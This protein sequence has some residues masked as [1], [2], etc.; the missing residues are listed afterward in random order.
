MKT[1]LLLAFATIL[2]LSGCTKDVYTIN[3]TVEIDFNDSESVSL[4]EGKITISYIKLDESRCPPN[5]VCIW[6]GQVA[7]TLRIDESN[8]EFTLG[9]H[10]DY[11]S[12]YTY[13]DYLITL[14]AVKYTSDKKFGSQKHSC[15][16][17]K[18]EKQ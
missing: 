5:V 3:D 11:D 6:A 7:V 8:E 15:L 2:F 4:T 12:E 1:S 9:F 13:G 14:L 18:V 16:E 17:L 10:E